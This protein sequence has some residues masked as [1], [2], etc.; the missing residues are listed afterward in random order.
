[1]A[2]VSSQKMA[3]SL[4]KPP[5]VVTSA[6]R[7]RSQTDEAEEITVEKKKDQD[8][9]DDDEEE[10]IEKEKSRNRRRKERDPAEQSQTSSDRTQM[11]PLTPT[12]YEPR[13]LP[14][15]SSPEVQPTGGELWV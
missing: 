11:R 14:V 3:P 13:M 1:M 7:P 12:V 9:N 5:A 10:K 2:T 4:S 15:C 8:K 6:T